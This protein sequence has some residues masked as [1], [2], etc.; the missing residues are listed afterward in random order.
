M[1]AE[2]KTEPRGPFPSDRDR[3][4][5]EGDRK[6]S[7]GGAQRVYERAVSAAA[8][9]AGKRFEPFGECPAA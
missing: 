9:V 3:G 4:L 8:H 2:R 1:R 6:P 5:G 7:L